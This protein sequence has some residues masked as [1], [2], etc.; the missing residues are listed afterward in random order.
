MIKQKKVNSIGGR[1]GAKNV[2]LSVGGKK[3]RLQELIPD[4][5]DPIS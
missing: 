1:E 5:C 4:S 2:K 3:S